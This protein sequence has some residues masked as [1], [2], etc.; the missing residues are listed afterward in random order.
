MLRLGTGGSSKQWCSRPQS[1]RTSLTFASRARSCCCRSAVLGFAQTG[2]YVLYLVQKCLKEFSKAF[3]RRG[4]CVAK[5]HDRQAHRCIER[6]LSDA[7]HSTLV[8]VML[9]SE[10]TPA[11]RP[12]CGFAVAD[13]FLVESISLLFVER[14]VVFTKEA[15]KVGGN[16]QQ[17]LKP[18]NNRKIVKTIVTSA[19]CTCCQ[20][21]TTC[22][23][24]PIHPI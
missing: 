20:N 2:F 19:I 7:C 18:G 21:D 9:E 24:Q 15:R 17:I 13:D 3:G 22:D 10:T 11:F 1:V 14:C 23:R 5:S 8:F 16:R 6:G 12:R 4:P